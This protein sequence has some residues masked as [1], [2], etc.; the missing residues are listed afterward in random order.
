MSTAARELAGERCSSCLDIHL[1]DYNLFLLKDYSGGRLIKGKVAAG[2]NITLDNFS[3]GE[4]LPDDNVSNTLVAGGNLTL[5]AGSVHGATWYGGSYTPKWSVNIKRGPLTQGTPP[6]FVLRGFAER[7]TDLLALSSRLA[8]QPVNGKTQRQKW[9]ALDL[10]GTDPCLNVF[11]VTASD[12]NEVSARNIN[13][14]TGSFALVNIRG[15]A[16]TPLKGGFNASINPRRVLYNFVDATRLEARDFGLLGTV[17]APKADLVFN[18]G[19]W[20]GGIYAVSLNGNASGNLAPLDELAGKAE[21]TCNEVDDDCNG[22]VDDG[23]ECT[24]TATQ[25][26]T[27]WC[28][29]AGTR[30]CDPATCGYGECVSSSCCRADAD[31]GGGSYCEG[32]TCAVQKENG[33]ECSSANQCASG[34]CVDGVCCNSACDGECDACDLA[35]LKGTCSMV[36]SEVK[37]RASGGDCD[38]AEYCTGAEAACPA[39]AVVDAGT[40]CRAASGICDVA[41][42]C[43][44]SSKTCPLDGHIPNGT[45]CGT[46]TGDWG[47]CEGFSDYCDPTGTESRPVTASTCEAGT[48]TLSST[49]T[50]T[51]ACTRLP[52]G[53]QPC[54]ADSESWGTCGGFSDTCDETGTRS[55]SKITYKYDCATGR[56]ESTTVNDTVACTR[57]TAGV[58]CRTAADVCDVAETCSGGVCPA[59]G[60]AP[61]G[62]S[63]ND[64]NTCTTSDVCNG[65]GICRGTTPPPC[66]ADSE[67]VGACGGFGDTCGETGTR[68][69]TKTTYKYNCATAKC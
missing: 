17:L 24:G 33:V 19:G 40:S 5:T 18:N 13:V 47:S 1:S 49:S 6:D 7:F 56:C 22:Q 23:F 67:T 36:S 4:A 28:G 12:F 10:T 58:Q 60:K 62:T 27:A 3:V 52:P 31:C 53:P 21:E 57:S 42:V 41:E 8:T 9:G 38:V 20:T 64:N 51:Q 14:P 63:C 59:D 2:G 35:G 25:S 55:H 34:Q 50:D 26:C 30:S 61:A 46:S 39:D 43:D 45:S 37:C 54:P 32:T 11:E 65:T 15:T 69:R 66:P 44:G 16:S 68:L 48:C 29:A